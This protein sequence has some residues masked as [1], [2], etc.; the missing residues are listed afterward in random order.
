MSENH[1]A[2]KTDSFGIYAA[3]INAVSDHF[4]DLLEHPPVIAGGYLSNGVFGPAA[5]KTVNLVEQQ[6]DEVFQNIHFALHMFLIGPGVKIER[7][8][9]SS[10]DAG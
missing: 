9:R 5:D 8:P 4:R 3:S 2:S 1:F 10:P 6:T 7:A